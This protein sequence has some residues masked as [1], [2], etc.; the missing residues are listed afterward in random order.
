MEF[1]QFNGSIVSVFA[2]LPPQAHRLFLGFESGTSV[3]QGSDLTVVS[4]IVHLWFL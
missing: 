3:S 1:I 2:N 4:R